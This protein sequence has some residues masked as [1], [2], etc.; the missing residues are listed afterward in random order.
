[1][2]RPDADACELVEHFGPITVGRQRI[3]QQRPAK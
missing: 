1:V 2:G 3:G